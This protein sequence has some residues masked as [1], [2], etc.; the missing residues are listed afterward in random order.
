ME[1]YCEIQINEG[2]LRGMMNQPKQKKIP[3]IYYVTR[4]H[5]SR[6]GPRF[7]FAR[8]ARALRRNL[9]IGSIRFDF[10]G[11]GESDLD[12]SKNEGNE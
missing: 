8:L 2:I 4:L 11:S 10:L 1:V 12:F 9:G 7:A 6:V 5:S 3:F